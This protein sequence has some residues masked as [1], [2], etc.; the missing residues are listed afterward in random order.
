[1]YLIIHLTIFVNII[2]IVGLLIG[3]FYNFVQPKEKAIFGYFVVGSMLAYIILMC[4]VAI[5]RLIVNPDLWCLILALCI[6]SPFVVGKLVRYETLKKYTIIQ[7][8]FFLVSL[9]IL[10][11]K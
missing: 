7:I 3:L 2:A 1:M 6:I 11:I 10:L 9:V 4:L 5:R 8:L